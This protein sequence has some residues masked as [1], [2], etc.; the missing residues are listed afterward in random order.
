VK[1]KLI[2]FDLDDTLLDTT[3]LLI[4]IARTQAFEDRIVQPLPLMSG[5]KENLDYLRNKYDLVLLTQG[6]PDAQKKKVHSLGISDYFKKHYFADPSINETKA[7]YFQK[8]IDD[9]GLAPENIM[10]IGNRRYTDIREAKKLGMKTCLFHYGEH[11]DEK[12]SQNEDIPDFTVIHH[13]E[14]IREC[15]L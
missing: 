9:S 13:K 8:I 11:A 15:H 12:I 5:A 4:P 10:S 1:I 7:Q 3:R 2:V 6:R 14:L